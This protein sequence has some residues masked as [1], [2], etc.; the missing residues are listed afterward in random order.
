MGEF[1]SKY[2]LIILLIVNVISYLPNSPIGN[3]KTL[4]VNYYPYYSEYLA[5]VN[6]FLPISE[7]LAFLEFYIIVASTLQLLMVLGRI[8]AIFPE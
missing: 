7:I 5:Y 1:L 4:I 8:A 3:I 6:W 2:T